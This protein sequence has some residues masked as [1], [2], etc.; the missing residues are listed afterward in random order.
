MTTAR[1][2]LTT[3]IS[4]TCGWVVADLDAEAA[5]ACLQALTDAGYAIVPREPTPQMVAAALPLVEHDEAAVTAA[6]GIAEYA[7]LWLSPE[8][9]PYQ[10]ID[11]AVV[12]AAMDIVFDWRAMVAAAEEGGR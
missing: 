12:P 4:T 6:K 3:A 1:E 7:V 5:N 10:P 9:R 11:V 8:G 2:V